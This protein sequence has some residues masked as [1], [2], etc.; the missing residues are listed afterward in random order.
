[1]RVHRLFSLCLAL[2]F[3]L[4]LAACP[5]PDGPDGPQGP[6]GK[7]Y[8]VSYYY[9]EDGD[10]VATGEPDEVIVVEE[11]GRAAMLSL[12]PTPSS[13][14][15][16]WY[17][18][19]ADGTAGEKWDINTPVTADLTLIANWRTRE[20]S[21]RYYVD[22]REAF[23]VL[24]PYGQTTEDPYVLFPE[25]CLYLDEWKA[26]VEAGES[27]LGWQDTAGEMWDFA[28][29]VVQSDLTLVAVFGA[30]T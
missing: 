10:G 19:N 18:R 27:F 3:V 5:S 17:V 8:T 9:D 23:S 30:P 11:N 26:R 20:Y 21:V 16:G 22:G 6:S 2:L 13:E 7:T 12:A 24:I 4:A 28:T 1:M 29:D 14:I 15:E 25:E